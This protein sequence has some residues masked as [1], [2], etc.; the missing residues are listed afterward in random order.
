MQALQTIG[1][2]LLPA[3]RH[4]ST[5]LMLQCCNAM[6]KEATT[7][8]MRLLWFAAAAA[9]AAARYATCGL[10]MMLCQPHLLRAA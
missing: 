2:D 5:L 10:C 8:Q 6:L 9:A 4:L 1:A 3:F 7:M